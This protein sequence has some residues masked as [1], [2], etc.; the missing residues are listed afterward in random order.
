M[1]DL[2]R[3]GALGAGLAAV[4]AAAPGATAAQDRAGP[5][6]RRF[7]GKV[8][9]ITGATS[10]IGRAAAFAFAREGAKVGFCG[11]REALGREVEAQLRATG[12]E[13]LYIR[14]DV[15]DPAQVQAFVDGTAERFGRLDVGFNNAG[16]N[17]FK[18]LHETS[19]EEWNEMA[20]TNTRGVFLAMKYQIPHLLRAGGGTLVITS[21]MH[22]LATRPGGAAYG[23]SKRALMGLCQAAAMDYGPN[24][25]RVNLVTPGIVNTRMFTD[26]LRTEAERRDAA[27]GVDALKR[28]GTPEEIAE[29]ALFLASDDCPYLT[30]S[31]L[32][33][34]GGLMAGI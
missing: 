21:S 15:R 31:S 12:A 14:A 16:I 29:A 4:A 18:A 1:P 6:R 28:I 13:A 17:W 25:I 10:G 8:V 32:L 3:R 23:G 9:A 20:E 5:A 34:D 11:R 2:S 33:V 30:G 27:A 19:V 7:E 22:E 24:N 26:R